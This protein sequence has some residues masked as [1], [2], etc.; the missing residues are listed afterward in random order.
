MVSRGIEHLALDHCARLGQVGCKLIL[1]MWLRDGRK[2][3]FRPQDFHD[4]SDEPNPVDTSG[5]VRH[6]RSDMLYPQT[7]LWLSF[8]LLASDTVTHAIKRALSPATAYNREYSIL[9]FEKYIIVYLNTASFLL[10]LFYV[11]PE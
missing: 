5:H 9:H 4:L 6:K 2:L 7:S 3:L 11:P 8:G 10:F 1:A